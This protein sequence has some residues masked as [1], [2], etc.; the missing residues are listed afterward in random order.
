MGSCFSSIQNPILGCPTSE[1]AELMAD[2]LEMSDKNDQYSRNNVS[3][4]SEER[5]VIFCGQMKR[6]E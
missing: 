3:I 5:Q 4:D 2:F 1:K 6:E